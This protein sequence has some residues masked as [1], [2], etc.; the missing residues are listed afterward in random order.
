MFE[1]GTPM[2]NGI[3]WKF[4]FKEKY[5]YTPDENFYN[6]CKQVIL[7]WYSESSKAVESSKCLESVSEGETI[8]NSLN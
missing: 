8:F 6:N 4:D 1:N 7:Y 3:N 2:V 5:T